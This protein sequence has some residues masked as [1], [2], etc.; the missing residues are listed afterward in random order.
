M[1]GASERRRN[2]LKGFQEFDLKAKAR[3]W[4]RQSDMCRIRST[5][6]Q[7][8]LTHKKTPTPRTLQNGYAKS[9]T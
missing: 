3:I 4:P 1:P 5:A 2:N 7:G 8:Y 9:P 6:V